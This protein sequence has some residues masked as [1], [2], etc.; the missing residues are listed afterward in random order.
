MRPVIRAC[1]AGLVS[2]AITVSAGRVGVAHQQSPAQT[3]RG[4][5]DLIAVD[6]QVV[7]KDGHPVTGLGPEKFD[8]AI[9]GHQRRVVSAV[10][11]DANRTNRVTPGQTPAEP[12]GTATTVSPAPGLPAGRLIILAIDCQSFNVAV[13]RGLATAARGFVQRLQPTDFVGLYAYPFGPKLDPTTDHASVMRA[14]D[15][16]TGQFIDPSEEFHLKPAELVDMSA[17]TPPSRK[18][19]RDPFSPAS[20]AQS[21]CSDPECLARLQVE[22]AAAVRYYETQG[23]ASIEMFRTLLRNL[24]SIPGRKTVVLVSAGQVTSDI[25]GGRPDVGEIGIEV[26]RSAARA[27]VSVYTLFIDQNLLTGNSAENRSNHYTMSSRDSN[28]LGRW[29]DEFSGAAGGALMKVLAGNGEVAFDRILTETSAFYLLG[30]EPTD[31]DRD[32]RAHD[33]KVKVNQRNVTVRARASVVV[34]KRP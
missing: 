13:S 18:T 34:P 6:V 7:D 25:V 1:A 28:I 8:V 17:R 9:G 22:V 10:L 12:A 14:L 30:V 19:G 32:G 24:G 29:L 11:L 31:A 21:L 20:V 2:T 15:T 33:I 16:V 4:A 26:G 3:F 23:Q 27:N 5:I